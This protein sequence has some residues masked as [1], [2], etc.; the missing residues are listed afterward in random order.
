[1]AGTMSGA[2]YI[3]AAASMAAFAGPAGAASRRIAVLTDSRVPAYRQAAEALARALPSPAVIDAARLTGPNA[4]GAELRAAKADILVAVGSHPADAV[5]AAGVPV[6]SSMTVDRRAYGGSAVGGVTLE[7]P[8]SG[9][10]AEL[11]GIWPEK[12]RIGV[13][14]AA[15]AGASPRPEAIQQARRAGFEVVVAEC[16]GPDRIIEALMTLKGKV[17]LVWC[18]PDAA[19]F[20][21]TTVP[22]LLMAALRNQLPV[23]GFSESFVKAGAAVGIYPDYADVGRQTA[24]LVNRYAVSG[25]GAGFEPPRRLRVA[26]NERVLRL[27]GLAVPARQ[28]GT[29]ILRVQ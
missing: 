3:L 16:A 13:L 29:S 12:R 11:A 4:L 22:P 8:L 27:I 10:L 26:V 19:L 5:A 24:D 25:P 18:P 14:R 17:D 6:I 15:S 2:A 21:A 20:N 1:M 9:A 7:V 23:V 28:G